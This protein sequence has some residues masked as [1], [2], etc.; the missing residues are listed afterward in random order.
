M[1]QIAILRVMIIVGTMLSCG[2]ITEA[3]SVGTIWNTWDKVLDGMPLHPEGS[4]GAYNNG[5]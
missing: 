3:Y 5:C 4:I 1:K 2:H